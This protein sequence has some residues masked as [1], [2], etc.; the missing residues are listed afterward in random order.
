MEKIKRLLKKLKIIFFQDG[1]YFYR[2]LKRYDLII[3]DDI[4][5]HPVSGFR[6]EEFTTLLKEFRDSKIV[7]DNISYNHI[8][9]SKTLHKDHIQQLIVRNP[10]IK[11]K[12]KLKKGLININTRLFYCL[13]LN[14]IFKNLV[15]IEK[16]KIPFVFTLYPGG[17][18][19]V[20]NS[21]IDRKLQRIFSSPYFQKVIVTQS[22]TQDYLID[23]QLCEPDKILFIFGGVVPQYSINNPLIN[24]EYYLMGKPTFDV[25]FCAAKYTPLG[26]DKGYDVFIDYAKKLATE[27]DFV[28]FH[29]IG[30]FTEEDID[31]TNILDKTTFYGYQDF[32]NLTV[33]YKKMDIIVSPNQPFVLRKGAFDGFPLGTVVEAVFNGVV[34]LVTDNLNQNIFEDGEELIIINNE[35]E[36]IFQK[37]VTL[38]EK[39]SLLRNIAE[40]GRRAFLKV[41]SSDTQMSKRIELLKNVISNN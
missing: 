21:E 28:R 25:C 8:N 6:F 24:K 14:N 2:G 10:G 29:I 4:F 31:L 41:Y 26:E 40:K 35:S 9:S 5:P 23:N 38:I 33:V 39:P 3:Y 36:D 1:F 17:G 20:N 32:E 22:Y 34:A 12:C 18:F 37:T 30:G 27:F 11:S 13:F 19:Q 16:Y 15:W 7:M